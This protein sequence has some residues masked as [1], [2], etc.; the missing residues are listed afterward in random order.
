MWAKHSM[1]LEYT[2]ECSEN[3]GFTTGYMLMIQLGRY[4]KNAG[5]QF[6]CFPDWTGSGP[7]IAK[8]MLSIGKP[9]TF[10]VPGFFHRMAEMQGFTKKIQCGIK[11][12]NRKA[13]L[14]CKLKT[15]SVRL[16]TVNL[17]DIIRMYIEGNGR[18]CN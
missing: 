16:M 15:R 10:A 13:A 12:R 14:L 6:R 18:M 7:S 5:G 8:S 11:L 3:N 4:D 2:E 17:H 1:S 9:G